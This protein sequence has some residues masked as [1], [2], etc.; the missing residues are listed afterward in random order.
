MKNE[1][2]IS[3]LPYLR[4][5][6]NMVVWT[7]AVGLI[8]HAALVAQSVLLAWVVSRAVIDGDAPP[9]PAIVALGGIVL[10]RMV[11]TWHEMDVSHAVAYRI[12]AALRVALFDGFARGVP[13]RD[14]SQHTGRLASTAMADVERLEFFYAHTTAQLASAAVLVVA[15]TAAAFIVD[16]LLGLAVPVASLLLLAS[17]MRAAAAG[18]ALGAEAQRARESVGAQTVDVLGGSREVIS[19][20]LGEHVIS[21]LVGAGETADEARTRVDRHELGLQQIRELTI[22]VVVV[23]VLLLAA[24]G[25]LAPVD[26]APAAVGVLALLAPVASAA[27]SLSQVYPHRQSA[28]RV[29]EGIGLPAEGL[30]PAPRSHAEDA[31]G[32]PAA[33]SGPWGCTLRDV[34]FTYTRG[35][36]AGDA[37]QAIDDLVCP[38]VEI[39]P[40]EHVALTGPSGSGKTT[41]VRMLAGLWAP[42]AGS[43]QI[44]GAQGLRIPLAELPSQTRCQRIAVVDQDAPL[45]HGTLRENLLLGNPQ[46]EDPAL[47]A[48]LAA[49]GVDLTGDRWPDGLGTRIGESGTSLSGGQRARVALARALAQDPWLLILDETTASLDPQTEDEVIRSVRSLGRSVTVIAVS[50]RSSTIE[51]M[52][53]RIALGTD[54]AHPA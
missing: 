21:R 22:L 28:R 23:G 52:D 3:L 37:E 34:R 35:A 7:A 26:V 9:L 13:S 10:V 42:D 1:P 19:Y 8:N 54:G 51:A 6:R 24:R 15:G 2:L 29:L 45:F 18:D 44:Y 46:A 27:A 47:L 4:G 11:A 5:E 17:G 25:S 14:R 40:G 16:P 32:S 41:L 30:E 36:E 53:R 49:A 39:D 50:H 43:I 20:Q 12:L 31:A 48:A 33:P 38:L